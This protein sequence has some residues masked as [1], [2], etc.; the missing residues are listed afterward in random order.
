MIELPEAYTIAKQMDKA[1]KGSLIKSCTRG[2]S[3]HKFAFYNHTPE[4]YE[5]LMVGQIVGHSSYRGSYTITS[6]GKG[7]FLTLGGGGEKIILHEGGKT[8]PKKHQLLVG[9]H[10]GRYLSLTVQG[11]G[12]AT[13]FSG[14]EIE[15]HKYINK[16]GVSPETDEFSFVYFDGLFNELDADDK[17]S[18]KYFIV[19]EPGV[20]G[21]ANGYL[22]DILFRAKLHPKR[23]AIDLTKDERKGL[24]KA[25][26]ETVEVA[27]KLGG[28]DTESD[29]YGNPGR[30]KKILDSRTVG[31]PCPACGAIIEKVQFLG[32]ASYFCPKCQPL[33]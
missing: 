6:V 1:L 9:F 5:K 33:E 20:I 32:G 29:L 21:I 27:I 11:W 2:N 8:V 15:R 18:V 14:A 23:R 12:Q 28:R 30:Y 17:R 25:I 24:Y 3:P 13:L 22:Q 4:E 19:S 31:W 10:D 26:K 7:N 16:K